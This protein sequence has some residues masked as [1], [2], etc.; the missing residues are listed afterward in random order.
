MENSGYHGSSKPLN[1]QMAR[2]NL[3]YFTGYGSQA[4]H[5]CT[6]CSLQW[7]AENAPENGICSGCGSEIQDGPLPRSNGRNLRLRQAVGDYTLNLIG[8]IFDSEAV[9]STPTSRCG[10][11]LL[12]VER[13][14]H[15][16]VPWTV[17]DLA[18]VDAGGSSLMWS[19]WSLILYMC[20]TWS[21]VRDGTGLV[22]TG[23][24]DGAPEVLT[25]LDVVLVQQ[26]SI[27]LLKVDDGAVVSLTAYLGGLLQT[28]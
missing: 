22:R 6:A 20:A 11:A 3:V 28:G 5:H 27:P 7:Q 24:L 16:V 21:S 12:I 25:L 15:R 13:F 23:L 1:W 26:V 14:V 10:R 17:M 2:I 4:M 19:W 18:E 8:F 9:G